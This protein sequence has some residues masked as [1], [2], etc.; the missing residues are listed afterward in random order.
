MSTLTTREFIIKFVNKCPI[1]Y[2]TR[3]D[4]TIKAL[5]NKYNKKDLVE[6]VDFLNKIRIVYYIRRLDYRDPSLSKK[7]KGK[8][9]YSN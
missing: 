7:Y 8:Y 5:I 3:L 4:K 6:E 9:S 2:S 1:V